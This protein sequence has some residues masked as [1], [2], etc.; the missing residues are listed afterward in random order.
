MKNV[1]ISMNDEV[2]EWARVQAAKS[3]QSLSAWVGAELGRLRGGTSDLE[4]AMV[5]VLRTPLAPMSDGGRTFNRDE[6][7]DRPIFKRFR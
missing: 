5:A 7:Y 6:M 2:A 1:T 3:G 4:A